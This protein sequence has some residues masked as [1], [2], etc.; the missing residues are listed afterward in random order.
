MGRAGCQSLGIPLGYEVEIAGRPV[1][2]EIADRAA[3]QIDGRR[4][5]LGKGYDLIQGSTLG[6][7]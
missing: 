5:F 2:E 3:D 6:E 4:D 7:G 1:E